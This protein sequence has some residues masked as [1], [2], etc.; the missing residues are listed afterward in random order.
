MN[1]GDGRRR[2][3]AGRGDGRKQEALWSFPIQWGLQPLLHVVKHKGKG[4]PASLRT[5]K[6][7]GF[8]NEI[9]WGISREHPP[10]DHRPHKQTGK[11]LTCV[12][13]EK[14]MLSA[15]KVINSKEPSTQPTSYSV[16]STEASRE[17]KA[18][19]WY[20]TWWK[21][22]FR[23]MDRPQIAMRAYSHAPSK[24][25]H[26]SLLLVGERRSPEH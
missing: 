6:H 13:T 18:R 16:F 11:T 19:R 9:P 17:I 12:K 21:A 4:P 2:E 24:K 25:M 15:H 10:I 22:F 23:L 8:I 7:K 20:V 14:G 5:E 1:G 3:W 26:L